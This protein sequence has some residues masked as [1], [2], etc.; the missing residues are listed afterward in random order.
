MIFTGGLA[1]AVAAQIL[2]VPRAVLMPGVLLLSMVGAYAILGSVTAIWIVLGLGLLGYLMAL[3]D[4]P[5]APAVLGVVLGQVVEDN[6]MV[7]MMKAQGDLMQFF[8][9]DAAAVLGVL[10]ILIWAF[11]LVRA[12]KEIFSGRKPIQ[13][14]GRRA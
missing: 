5:V 11:L 8:D 6:F 13:S 3:A 9:R 2:R 4:I 1:I 10:T 14:E 12:A 7:S